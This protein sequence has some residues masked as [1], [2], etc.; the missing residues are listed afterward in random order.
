MDEIRDPIAA[1]THPDPW[2]YYDRLA[3]TAMHR[4]EE[5]GMWIAASALDVA[6][7][8]GHPAAR[9][10]PLD[11][12]VPP[13]L[14]GTVAGNIFAR[15]VRMN[16]TTER[17]GLKVAL[18]SALASVGTVTLDTLCDEAMGRSAAAARSDAALAEW[19]MSTLPTVVVARAVGVHIDEADSLVAAAGALA[20]AFAPGAPTV[21]AG[22]A[23]AAATM[24]TA[25]VDQA[26]GGTGIAARFA[27]RAA[28]AD[29]DDVLANLVGLFFQNFDATAGL[30]GNAL[31]AP[32][33]S[34]IDD[35]VRF[36]PPVHNTRRFVHAPTTVNGCAVNVGDTILLVLAAA[37]R[38]A[39]NSPVFSFGEG[40]HACPAR[41]FAPRLAMNAL[42]WTRRHRPALGVSVV[43]HRPSL[44]A[45]IPIFATTA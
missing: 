25:A 31:A 23:D 8:L 11:A 27:S 15:L 28:G 26:V 12:P 21:D 32:A 44:N 3:S 14:V 35:I 22:V 13:H 2:A 45:R 29:R 10:R 38:D 43:G 33:G 39:T 19:V 34:T 41:S 37:N 6:A 30:I 36:H 9:V 20:A 5:T 16:D 18:E 42:E 1:V 4:N 40:S 7:V 17:A 24:L